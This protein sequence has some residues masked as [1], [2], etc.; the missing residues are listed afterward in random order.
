MYIRA[1]LVKARLVAL[2]GHQELLKGE[3][4]IANL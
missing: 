3:E 2:N 1:L 4:I